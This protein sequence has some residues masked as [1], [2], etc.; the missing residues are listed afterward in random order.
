MV[1]IYINVTLFVCLLFSIYYF[2]MRRKKAEIT[3]IKSALPSICFFLIATINLSGM[4]F[5]LLGV[6][7]WTLTIVLLLLGAYFTKHL[8]PK[9]EAN[10]L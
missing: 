4:V 3:G 10:V 8:P 5:N 1:A 6:F 9:S 2:L 7:S